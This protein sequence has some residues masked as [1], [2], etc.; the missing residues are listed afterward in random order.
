MDVGPFRRLNEDA[1][2]GGVAPLGAETGRQLAG[3]RR[4]Q[5][6][7]ETGESAIGC[8]GRQGD[9]RRLGRRLFGH[10]GRFVR[11]DGVGLEFRLRRRRLGAGFGFDRFARQAFPFRLLFRFGQLSRFFGGLGFGGGQGGLAALFGRGRFG[12]LLDQFGQIV[13]QGAHALLVALQI[14]RFLALGGQL[15]RQGAQQ[16]GPLG[17]FLDQFGLLVLLLLGDFFQFILG[18]L[19]IF[20]VRFDGRQIGAQRVQQLGLGLRQIRH[21]LQIA[22][23]AIRVVAGQQQLD[24]VFIA[25]R[26]VLAQDGGQLLFLGGDGGRQFLAGGGQVA[27][28]GVGLVLLAGQVAQGA[29]GVGNRFFGGGQGVGHVVLFVLRLA[30]V[31]LQSLQLLRDAGAAGLGRRFLL[32][33]LGGPGRRR[34]GAAAQGQG[35][36]QRQGGLHGD[37]RQCRKQQNLTSPYLG[38]PRRRWRQQ[39]RPRRP[40]SN[41]G[42]VSGRHR[43]RRPGAGRWECSSQRCLRR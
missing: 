37:C 42:S 18:V 36:Q 40:D 17:F 5:L 28:F 12:L 41:G 9:F 15:A 23:D 10:L 30:D 38:W 22:V 43:V 21:Q 13:D 26:V 1:L 31:F 16:L 3:H 25:G 14:A 32:A 20:L 24:A 33:A 35:E 4:T 27:Q 29:V 34:Q 19:R 11:V 2:P 6:T 39:W 7:L 8:G